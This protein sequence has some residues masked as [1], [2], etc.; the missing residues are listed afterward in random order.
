MSLSLKIK[1]DFGGF[2]LDMELEADA[3]PL[4]LLG[5][6]GCGKSMT[7]RC[8]AGIVTPDEGYIILNGK[9][10]FDS[11]QHI[12]LPPQARRVGLMFQNYALFP[13]M[14]VEQNI[15]TGIREQLSRQ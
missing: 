11:A 14:T 15:L 6:S 8:I 10:L 4:A 1:K 12:N 3:E 13:N 7:L 2:V 9:T 5:G